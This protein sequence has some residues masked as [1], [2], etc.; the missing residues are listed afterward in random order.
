MTLQAS[1]H[2]NE[3]KRFNVLCEKIRKVLHLEHKDYKYEF[4][5]DDTK[6]D[7][8]TRTQT[9][10]WYI[11]MYIHPPF[12]KLTYTQQCMTLLHEHI[13]VCLIPFQQQVDRMLD[14]MHSYDKEHFEVSMVKGLELSVTHLEE[15]F[16]SL[17]SD[18]L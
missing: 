13:H 5:N 10:G 14:A 11:R 2:K 16:Y 18:K 9:N 1:I 17:L 3:T 6:A 7:A 4:T 12:W 15:V 8:G